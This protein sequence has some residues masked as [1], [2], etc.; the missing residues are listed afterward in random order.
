MQTQNDNGFLPEG[1]EVPAAASNYLKFEDGDNKFRIMSRPILGWLDWKE[2][3]PLRFKMNEKPSQPVDPSKPIKHFWAMV[4]FD[5]KDS[6]IKIVE[7]TQKSVISSI[8]KL[9]NSPE[10]GSP[11]NYDINVQKKGKSME[12]EYSVIPSPPKPVNEA[13][14]KAYELTNVDLNKLFLGE[15][16]FEVK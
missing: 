5:Y 7:L 16:P 3:K 15:D 6:K 14:K 1:Y 13:A 4:C 11:L 12:T 10:W 2:K 8:E 9:I